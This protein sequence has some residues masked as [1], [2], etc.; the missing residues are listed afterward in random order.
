SSSRV[1]T[2]GN[3]RYPAWTPDS[4]RISY[5]TTTGGGFRLV[6]RPADGS[7]AEEVLIDSKFGEYQPSWTSDGKTA[8]VMQL[9][10]ITLE[11]IAVLNLEDRKVTPL[12]HERYTETGARLS[13]DGKWLAYTA[14][15]AA[16]AEVFVQ[17]FPAPGPRWQIS[18]G[19]GESPQWSANGREIFYS[20]R[21]TVMSVAVSPKNGAL[22]AERPRKVFEAPFEDYGAMPDGRHFVTTMPT[23]TERPNR[24]R[25]V[26]N[27]QA[28]LKQ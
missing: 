17:P 13:P 10:P 11:D 9:N 27:W 3:N 21:H 4:R 23:K 25:L 2:Q 5:T 22:N 8:V 16:Q 7:G 6:W 18:V 26:L 20:V 14:R 28:E 15:V 1:T 24:I 19:G 12:L